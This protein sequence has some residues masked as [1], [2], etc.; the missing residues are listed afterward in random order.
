MEGG[1]QEDRGGQNGRRAQQNGAAEPSAPPQPSPQA[2]APMFAL[3]CEMCY[4]S[5]GL[6]VTRVTVVNSSGEV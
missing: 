5:D 6:E 1:R 2:Q 3:D 4:T